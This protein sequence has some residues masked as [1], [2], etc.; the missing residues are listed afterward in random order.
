M[1]FLLDT[2][3]CIYAMKSRPES[4]TRRL[5]AARSSDLAISSVTVFELWY[6]VQRSK[7]IARNSEALRE[8]LAPLRQ[9]EFDADDAA[10][11]GK[12]RAGLDTKGTPIGPY[13]LQIAAQALRRKLT[14]VTHD[15]A[16]FKRISGLKVAD[17]A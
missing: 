5:A 11:C 13:D 9:L 17:W 1:R 4:V 2:N 8:F 14:L 10:A 15:T 12:I 6:G 3:I 7:A 16:E